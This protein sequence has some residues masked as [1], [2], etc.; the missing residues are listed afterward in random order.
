MLSD[1]FAI[2]RTDAPDLFFAA[3]AAVAVAPC[4]LVHSAPVAG[5]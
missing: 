5:P 1:K 2:D 4:S 3:E